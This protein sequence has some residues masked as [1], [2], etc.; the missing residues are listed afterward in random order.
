[1]S[2]F[3][4]SAMLPWT[5][6]AT[7]HHLPKHRSCSFWSPWSIAGPSRSR[8]SFASCRLVDAVSHNSSASALFSLSHAA[9]ASKSA[10]L[11][12]CS[13]KAA[14]LK[15]LNF[16][17]MLLLS[18]SA[19]RMAPMICSQADLQCWRSLSLAMSFAHVQTAEDKAWMVS[20]AWIR[21]SR[22]WINIIINQ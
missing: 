20:R 8:I 3:Q 9:K 4:G 11:F 15:V 21:R 6:P 22:S 13:H 7:Y 5:T 1:M 12:G 16:Q 10:N 14:S 19:L 2:F 17:T 18:S